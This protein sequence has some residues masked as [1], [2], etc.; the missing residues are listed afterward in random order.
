VHVGDRD[1]DSIASGRSG[2]SVWRRGRTLI[3]RGRTAPAANLSAAWV[4]RQAILLRSRPLVLEST[5][6]KVFQAS[7]LGRRLA[8]SIVT[9]VDGSV[10]SIVAAQ[11]RCAR[12]TEYS[13]G[14]SGRNGAGAARGIDRC[15]RSFGRGTRP[16]SVS[17]WR[18]LDAT[19]VR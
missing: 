19:A 16:S 14:L 1:R 5:A 11:A 9:L 2:M 13:P 4:L 6:N 15:D 10:P 8:G 17:R 12:Q 7:V 18:N 3:Y